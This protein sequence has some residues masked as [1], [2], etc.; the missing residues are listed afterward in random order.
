[1]LNDIHDLQ[2]MPNEAI[3]HHACQLFDMKWQTKSKTDDGN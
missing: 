2:L 3:F 1:M